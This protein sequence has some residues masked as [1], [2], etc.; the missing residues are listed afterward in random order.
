MLLFSWLKCLLGLVLWEQ[1]NMGANPLWWVTCLLE[2]HFRI[3]SQGWCPLISSHG[4]ELSLCLVQGL[5]SRHFW[6]DVDTG[7][8]ENAHENLLLV[9]FP[10]SF[11]FCLSKAWP[12]AS[13]G[14]QEGFHCLWWVLHAAQAMRRWEM[15]ACSWCLLSG[16]ELNSTLQQGSSSGA[17]ALALREKRWIKLC[18]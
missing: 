15:F 1:G 12:A 13:W 4:A 16:E 5:V 18:S 3:L 17:R 9:F 11:Q 2:E 10:C 8:A 14:Q 6:R 7:G